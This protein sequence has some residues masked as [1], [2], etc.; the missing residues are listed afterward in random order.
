MMENAK[1]FMGVDT[2]TQSVR[3]AVT[4]ISGNV[5][6]S[7]EQVYETTY[8]KPG[9]AEQKPDDWWRC[10][11]TAVGNVTSKLSMGIRYSIEAISVCSTSSTVVPVDAEGEALQN[12]IMWMDTRAVK[13]METCN[14]TNH[15]YLE[16]C[17]GEDSV[18]WMIPKVLWIKNNQP[19]IYAKSYKIIEQLDW[20]NYKLCGVY[21][22][23][24]CQA[25]CKWNYVECEGGW[26]ADFFNQIGLEDYADKLVLDVKHV[27]DPLGK[28]DKAFA[29]KYDLN[30]NMLVVEGGIDAHIGMLGMGV[31]KAGKLAMIMGT[32]FVQLCFSD[33]KL[34]LDGIWGPYNNPIVP[35]LWLLEG[36]QI[37]AGSIVKWF[38]R[39][40]D[41][42]KLDN[43]YAH[44]NALIDEIEPGAEGLVALDFFQGNRTPYKDPNA[45]GV[46]YGLTLSHTKAHIYRALLE[47][48]ALGTK[49]IIDNFESQGCPINSIVGC[50]GV[51]K[52]ATWMQI[53][54][55]ATGKPIIVTV[56][57]SAGGLGCCIVASVGSGAYDNF[58]EA[59][60]GMV[61]EAYCVEPNPDHYDKYQKVFNTYVEIYDQ[62]KDTMAK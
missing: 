59:T 47:S 39:E 22:T 6:A 35:G 11:N 20:M 9:W 4:D 12:A 2:G 38:M 43:P 31:A 36:G 33:K 45:K 18:E 24:I 13:E 1:Y 25:A 53:I 3:V 5:V 54:A 10:F 57:P 29:E 52:D 15:P 58:E 40:W 32:S 28:I 55:D 44:M 62:L 27:G 21:A 19:D 17:G 37:S 46:I 16:Y 8:P 42:N 7:D 34:V 60:K 41:L 56:D 50:G 14:A 26:N 30:P 49:N 23:S 48:V 61:K 51:T